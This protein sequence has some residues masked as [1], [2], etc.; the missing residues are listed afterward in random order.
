MKVNLRRR[1][2]FYLAALVLCMLAAASSVRADGSDTRIFLPVASS[3]PPDCGIPGTSYHTLPIA[4]AP[5]D[6]PAS[7]H[8]DL[9]L[10]VRGFSPVSA[11]LSLVQYGGPTDDKAPQLDALFA[12]DRLPQFSSSYQVHHWDWSC[13][14]RAGPITDWDVTLLGMTTKPGEPLRVPASGYDIGGG[15]QV[16]VLYAA[17]NRITLKYTPEDNVVS[18]YTIHVED[19]CVE[20]D[21]RALYDQMNADGRERL[22]ALYGRQPFGR[23]LGTEVR[24]TVRDDGSFLDPRSQK[25][26]WKEYPLP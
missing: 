15:F 19:V 1:H 10:A 18:G 5:T 11:A 2:A 21:L 4:S 24:V 3:E 13:D 22:P 12:P 8:P 20:P 7:T 23:A 16:M 14:C 17:E 25:D 6:R 26:W 9:N